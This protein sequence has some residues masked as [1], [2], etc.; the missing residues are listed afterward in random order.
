MG[1]GS[2]SEL[3]HSCNREATQL[4]CES[5][6]KFLANQDSGIS[7]RLVGQ[8]RSLFIVDQARQHS[9][10]HFSEVRCSSPKVGIVR[11]FLL[12]CVAGK[13]LMPCR[14]RVQVLL[15]DF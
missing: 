7:E 10:F 14:R 15:L 2:A 3:D 8:S 5:R 1:C 13:G 11:L 4:L 6:R 9:S 12:G